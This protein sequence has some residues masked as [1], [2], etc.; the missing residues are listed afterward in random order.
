MS[1]NETFKRRD[2]VRR[3]VG[4]IREINR[5]YSKPRTHMSKPVKFSLLLLRLYLLFLVLIVVYKLIITLK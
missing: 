5:R 4:K 3:L 2:I 1:Q